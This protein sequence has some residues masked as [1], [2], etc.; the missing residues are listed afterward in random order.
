VSGI[1]L[2]GLRSRCGGFTIMLNGDARQE[3]YMVA[4]PTGVALY[5]FADIRPDRDH[6]DGPLSLPEPSSKSEIKAIR[7]PSG[8]QAGDSTISW[9]GSSA[10]ERPQAAAVDIDNADTGLIDRESDSVPV[11]RPRR[12]G[13]I[14]VD[15]PPSRAG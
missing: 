12:V 9:E 8:D 3:E 1:Q 14:P 4:A 5:S 11:W 7:R 10:R 6:H 13:R 15:H 2:G